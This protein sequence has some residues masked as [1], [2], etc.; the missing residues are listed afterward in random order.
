M[1]ELAIRSG[2]K[3]V[4]ITGCTPG[5]IGHAIAEEF[6]AKGLFVIASARRPEVL[7]DLAAKGIATVSLDVTSQESIAQCKEEVTKLTGGR[8]DFLVNNAGRTHTVPATDLD[9]DEIRATFETNV[10]GVMAMCKAFVSLLINARGLI[11]NIASLSAASP[12][13]FGSSY[14]ASKGAVVSYSRCLRQELRPFGVRVTVVMAGTVRSNIANTVHPLVEGSLYEPV[15]DLYAKRQ[16]YS[17][18]NKTMDTPAFARQVV[19]NALRPEVPILL[20]AWF[21]RRDWFWCGGMS[22]IVWL[23][24]ILGEW[25]L[26]VGAWRVFGLQKLKDYLD[27]KRK[28][29]ALAAKADEKTE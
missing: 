29:K 9:I 11:I 7:K 28:Q 1:S 12:Y 2:Q 13:I 3:S 23:G 4:L 6:H 15:A 10:F 8:L 26:D 17:Q 20:R 16:V 19:N 24:T 21:G 18:N 5:G 14:C 27:A 25:I 22:T